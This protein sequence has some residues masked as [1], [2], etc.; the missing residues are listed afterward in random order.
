MQAMLMLVD[1]LWAVFWSLLPDGL[2]Y[3]LFWEADEWRESRPLLGT[4]ISFDSRP[5]IFSCNL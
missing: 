2:L 1:D 5:F 3:G 4:A